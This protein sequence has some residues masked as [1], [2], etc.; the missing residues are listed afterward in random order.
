MERIHRTAG[1][2]W[3]KAQFEWEIF[4]TPLLAIDKIKQKKIT[5]YTKDLNNAIN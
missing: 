2:T 1:E 3:I 5:K 4:N